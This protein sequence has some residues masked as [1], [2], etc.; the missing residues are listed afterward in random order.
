LYRSQHR[1]PDAGI[2]GALE[3]EATEPRLNHAS[4]LEHDGDIALAGGA[5]RE[6]SNRIAVADD[7]NDLRSVDEPAQRPESG[8]DR[9]PVEGTE[10]S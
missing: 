10:L 1:S 2:E 5:G 4:W 3:S 7:V 9:S 6:G 8:W